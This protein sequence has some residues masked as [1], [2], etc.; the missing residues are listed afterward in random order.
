MNVM[1]IVSLPII[2]TVVYGVIELLK[3]VFKSE[4]PFRALLLR[5]ISL[6]Q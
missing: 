2:V 6:K 3:L 4:T 5:T 1:E